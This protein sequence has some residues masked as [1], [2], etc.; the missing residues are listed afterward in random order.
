VELNGEQKESHHQNSS[1]IQ[2]GNCTRLAWYRYVD[3]KWRS[4]SSF[5]DRL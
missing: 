1:T 4:W 3:K 2:S 5:T